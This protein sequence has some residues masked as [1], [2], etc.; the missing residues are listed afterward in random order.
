MKDYV[1]IQ[2]V[3]CYGK[4]EEDT[5]VMVCGFY[6]FTDADDEEYEDIWCGG[7]DSEGNP[8]RTW[9]GVVAELKTWASRA[10]ITIEELQ[11]D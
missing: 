9:T 6:Y 8:I 1:E 4:F 10:G 11:A 3:R 7:N 2:G 5:S